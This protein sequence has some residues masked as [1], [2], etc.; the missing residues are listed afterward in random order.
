MTVAFIGLMLG[1]SLIC[2][3]ESRAEKPAIAQIV[4]TNSTKDVL[5]FG[6]VKNGFTKEMETALQNGMPVTF[7]FMV[8]LRKV[9]SSWL[10]R[11]IASLTFDHTLSYDS[12]KEE[13]R[14]EL[15]EKGG[16]TV[17][18]RSLAEA[19][20]LMAEVNGLRVVPLS[21]LEADQDYQLRIKAKLVRKTLP[22]NLNTLIPFWGLWDFETEWH[23]VE[24]R[25]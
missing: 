7:T 5:L 25:Y 22:L 16:K 17:A 6:K 13:Y 3:S 9:R 4:I 21:R 2:P 8:Q 20:D 11:Q 15:Q 10:D 19:K 14:V 1:L 23:Q 12:L 24:F 18:T